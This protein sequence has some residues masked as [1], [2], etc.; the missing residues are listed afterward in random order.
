MNDKKAN[1]LPN[2]DNQLLTSTRGRID[3]LCQNAAIDQRR[4]I[5]LFEVMRGNTNALKSGKYSKLH[6]TPEYL[7]DYLDYVDNLQFDQPREI[8]ELMARIIKSN[9][10]RIT[11]KEYVELPDGEIGNKQ[12]NKMFRDTFVTAQSIGHFIA[13]QR[14]KMHNQ[15]FDM[16]DI[17]NLT[18]DERNS[19]LLVIRTALRRLREGKKDLVVLPS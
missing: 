8:I 1:D 18:D 13:I 14:G 16:Q 17:R 11:L 19:A 5:R 12:L 3:K 6:P 9:L 10:K 4:R 7:L 2:Q 15:Q